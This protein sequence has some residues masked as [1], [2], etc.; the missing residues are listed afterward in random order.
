M[1]KYFNICNFYILLWCLYSLQGT[2]YTGGSIISQ[3]ILA[4]LLVISLYY[5][6]YANI[7]FVLPPY[8]KMLNIMLIMF[9][10]YG[11]ALLLSPEP[12]YIRS[13]MTLV[14]KKDYLK[15]IY[16]SLLPI[17]TFFVFTKSGQLTESVIKKWIPVFL[18][19]IIACFF[20]QQSAAFARAAEVM[21]LREEFT[22]NMGY[23][24]LA[25]IPLLLFIKK[26]FV[27]YALFLIC[28]MFIIA[29]M[30]RGAILIF[31]LCL[32]LFMHSTLKAL[33]FR[34][35]ML[36][37]ILIAA[38][39]LALFYYVSYML[40]TSEYFN[41]RLEA[42]LEGDASNREDMY[43]HLLRQIFYYATPLQF[44]FGRGACGTLKVSDNFAHNDWLEIG[45]NQGL[46]GVVIYIAYWI[47]FFVTTQ[48]L[49]NNTIIYHALML[50]ML[51]YFVKT[52]FS[53]SYDDMPVYITLCIG[54]C[55]SH[56]YGKEQLCV[57]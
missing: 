5:T 38:S 47:A 49:K 31:A 33:S 53:M 26:P 50:T 29:A 22:N 15:N 11:G 20:R 14:S 40:D 16:M 25:I 28:G 56:Y 39:I 2:L 4:V 52:F 45:I 34:K 35:K 42:T 36:I 24:F 7:K 1:G 21:S 9:V 30:K 37:F 23:L 8:M 57:K 13:D 18:I 17:Y 3:G 41:T 54:Y 44:L 32:P 55:M 12:L 48:R 10:I 27:Q 51:V 19:I 6:I 43:P 46:L